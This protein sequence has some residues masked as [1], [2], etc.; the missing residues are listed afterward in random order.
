MH[1]YLQLDGYFESG[2]LSWVRK[3]L[4]DIH[5]MVITRTIFYGKSQNS[6]SSICPLFPSFVLQLDWHQHLGFNRFRLWFQL[7]PLNGTF[8]IYNSC[9]IECWM[10]LLLFSTFRIQW[11]SSLRHF[12]IVPD[13]VFRFFLD[14]WKRMQPWLGPRKDAVKETKIWEGDWWWK[15]SSHSFQLNTSGTDKTSIIYRLLRVD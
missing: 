12:L 2:K 1:L 11:I 5:F 13:S 4:D 9:C 10:S 15:D 6:I 3:R 14:S 8:L 7:Q